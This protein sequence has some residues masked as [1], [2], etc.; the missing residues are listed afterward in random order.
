MRQQPCCA[1][2]TPKHRARGDPTGQRRLFIHGM[3]PDIFIHCLR[4]S[5]DNEVANLVAPRSSTGTWSVRA[6]GWQTPS[7]LAAISKD[8]PRGWGEAQAECGMLQVSNVRRNPHMKAFSLDL[9]RLVR[10]HEPLRMTIRR[11]AQL[12]DDPSPVLRPGPDCDSPVEQAQNGAESSQVN[13]GA[14]ACN[15]CTRR[16]LSLSWW[17]AA[18]GT[19]MLGLRPCPPVHF[20][21]CGI[22]AT[23]S[24]RGPSRC[25]LLFGP[26]PQGDRTTF[27]GSTFL[28]ISLHRELAGRPTLAG[29]I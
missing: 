23:F 12:T 27:D 18:T 14:S 19:H 16:L 3:P 22:A 10:A 13:L 15:V 9:V 7:V 29:C 26:T 17:R 5:S 6:G 8:H 11:G 25:A 1:P 20:P 2:G 21:S 24:Q 4:G 28:A